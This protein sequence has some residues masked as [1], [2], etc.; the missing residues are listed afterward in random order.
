MM[1]QSIGTILSGSLTD[2]F[3]MRVH[4]TALIEQLKTGKFVCIASAQGSFFSMLV[5]LKLEVSHPD[6]LLFPPTPQEHLLHHI[7]MQQNMYAIAHLKPLLFITDQRKIIPVKTIPTHF[8]PVYEAQHE[9]ITLIF[10]NEAEPTQKYFNI[11]TP[12]DMEVPVCID[13]EKITERSNGIFGKT[14]TGKTFITRVLLA[15]LIKNDKA[16]TLIFDMHSEYGI[17]ARKEGNQANFVKGLKT[18]FP[19]KIAL[20]SLD[21]QTTLRRGASADATLTLAYESIA[22]DDILSLQDEFQLHPTAYEAAYL[23]VARY[24]K[25]WLIKLLEQGER[26]RE[27]AQEIGA[28]P[29]SLAALYRKLKQIERLPFF[30]AQS[31]D[32]LDLMLSYIEQGTSIIIEF[33]NFSS[34]LCYLLLANIITR[35]LHAAYIA[36][37]ERYL[38]S[39]KKSDEP[40]KLLITI[41]EAHKFLNP[42]A[43]RQTIFGTIAREMRKYYVSLLIVDQRPS[44][45][46]PE[47]LSQIGTKF[48]AQLT[49]EK[50]LQAVLS[51]T[52]HAHYLRT[53]L[54]M[55]ESKQQALL[56]GHALPLPIVVETRSYD[57]HFYKSLINYTHSIPTE[58]VQNLF[59]EN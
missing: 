8:A 24:K 48:I 29:E 37:T 14:G 42:Q 1:K 32:S 55:L 38:A 47:I 9:D 12:L 4:S 30:T 6:I 17:Q 51:G 56:M 46:D 33:G 41:E 44:G 40:K 34:T 43:A 57:E 26:I 49:D 15:G 35:R 10:G 28:H 39:Q 5:D 11:G 58:L 50:D 19:Q 53:I 54:A 18:L 36:K 20:F 27:C 16:V 59:S 23:L 3:M 45:I 22:V 52:A 31:S 25:Q 7:L 2:G 13:L 21:P